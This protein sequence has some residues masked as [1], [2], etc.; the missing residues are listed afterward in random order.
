M[1]TRSW[2][3]RPLDDGEQVEVG[4]MVEVL[5]R[6]TGAKF[7]AVVLDVFNNIEA[8]AVQ[9]DDLDGPITVFFRSVG[10]WEDYLL[11]G[12]VC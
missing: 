9:A 3:S 11:S 2:Q 6:S 8:V 7:T 1:T 10:N 4:Q 12:V 5:A